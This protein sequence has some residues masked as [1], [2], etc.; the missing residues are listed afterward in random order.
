MTNMNL[1]RFPAIK[2]LNRLFLCDRL[3]SESNQNKKIPTTSP[4]PHETLSVQIREISGNL[5][6]L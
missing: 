4:E 2:M 5:I 1:Q 6:P 3:Q